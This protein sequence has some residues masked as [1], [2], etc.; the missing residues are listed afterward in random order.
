MSRSISC[1][2]SNIVW[3][4]LVPRKWERDPPIEYWYQCRGIG[5]EPALEYHSMFAISLGDWLLWH[6][7]SCAIAWM[8]QYLGLHCVARVSLAHSRIWAG[9]LERRSVHAAVENTLIASAWYSWNLFSS[10]VQSM[11]QC[12]SSVV[13][14]SLTPQPCGSQTKVDLGGLHTLRWEDCVRVL[15]TGTSIYK[16][17]SSR[18]LG[19]W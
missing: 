13:F 9:R 5:S 2:G 10:K 4:T 11:F 12:S 19:Y 3:K 18:G 15:V 8:V 1:P 6:L 17:L 16:V 14:P 7:D